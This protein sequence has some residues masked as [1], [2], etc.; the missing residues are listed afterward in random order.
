MPP[1][2]RGIEEMGI[3][4]YFNAV[5][6]KIEGCMTQPD[7][8]ILFT[9]ELAAGMND[10]L[11]PPAAVADQVEHVGWQPSQQPDIV[12]VK[13]EFIID[14]SFLLVY[15][16]AFPAF[17]MYIIEFFIGRNEVRRR[18]RTLRDEISNAISNRKDGD[19]D[20]DVQ[21]KGKLKTK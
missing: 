4:Q 12:L 11:I 20:G 10:R 5:D 19:G 9:K 3:D 21:H 6:I 15:G 2:D 13:R 16:G 17:G 8:D 7:K 1:V 18:R 14:K